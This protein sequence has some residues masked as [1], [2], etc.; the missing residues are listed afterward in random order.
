MGTLKYIVEVSE[1]TEY[2]PELALSTMD[3]DKIY[4]IYEILTGD[5]DPGAESYL[6]SFGIVYD[7]PLTTNVELFFE[8][9]LQQV[10]TAGEMLSTVNTFYVTSRKIYMHLP[11]KPWEYKEVDTELQSIL[12]FSSGP[13]DEDNPSDLR[14]GNNF[15][16]TRLKIPRLTNKLSDTIAGIALFQTN[17]FTLANQDGKFDDAKI[18]NFFNTSAT[19][20]KTDLTMPT[21]DDY[22]TIKQGIVENQKTL[23]NDF[24]ITLASVFRDLD[25]PVCD[26]FDTATFPSAPDSTIGQEIPRI[27]GPTKKAKL[28]EVDTNDYYVGDGVTAVS[29]VY[30]KD[31]VSL[32]YTYSAGI[33]TVTSG[34]PKTADCTGDSSNKIGEIVRDLVVSVGYSYIPSIWDTT[35]TDSYISLS[36]S[37]NFYV[38]SGSIKEAVKKALLSDNAFL[39]QKNDSLLTLRQW[40]QTYDSHEI[41]SWRII[42]QGITKDFDEARK[43]YLTQIFIEYDYSELEGELLKLYDDS[44]A[45]T[46][47]GV[48]NKRETK[49]FSTRLLNETDAQDLAT[50]L[51]SRF[52]GLSERLTVKLGYETSGINILDMVDLTVLLGDQD[53]LFSGVSDW[54]VINVDPSQDILTLEEDKT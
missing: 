32:S 19:I 33:V 29:A 3:Y 17:T 50:R 47:A 52:G 45:D 4:N 46:I 40:G 10:D 25:Q 42:S 51:I 2:P 18:N 54:I 34:D 15:Y 5:P 20:K 14:I 53:R 23:E 12:G 7:S 39:I 9:A 1:R 43:R 41:D 36:K 24:I 31:G 37:I 27:W 11:R 28:Y 44:E 35:E 48:Y 16:E 30:D 49:T 26:V 6:S 13:I 21:Y 38:D 22:I 8:T